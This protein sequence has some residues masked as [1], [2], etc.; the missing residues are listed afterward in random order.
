MGNPAVTADGENA[1]P[2]PWLPMLPLPRYSPDAKWSGFALE[3][4]AV[5]LLTLGVFALAPM[6][7]LHIKAGLDDYRNALAMAALGI[8][9]RKFGYARLASLAEYFAL[10]ICAATVILVAIYIGMANAGPLWDKNFVAA[11][12]AL[13]FDWLGW[14]DVIRAHSGLYRVLD[15]L[16]HNI[17]LVALYFVILTSLMGNTARLREIFW[18]LFVAGLLTALGGWAWPALGPFQQFGLQSHGSFLP[19]MRHLLSRRDLNFSLSQLQGVVSFP[20]YHTVLA[21]G[22]M[23]A[24]RGMGI[25]G[26]IVMAACGAMLFSIPFFGG[27]YLVDMLAGAAVTALSFAAIRLTMRLMALI[28]LAAGRRG[29]LVYAGAKQAG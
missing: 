10:L 3:W 11:D 23:M 21:L 18:L 6:T 13:G 5:A 9:A 2:T 4:L 1:R 26:V 19:E 8:V 15:R 7:G 14:F 25:T 24:F 22:L 12:R 17:G 28:R 29:S 27:H 16:Y 20:S